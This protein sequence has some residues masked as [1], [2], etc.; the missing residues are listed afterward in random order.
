MDSIFLRLLQYYQNGVYR[1]NIEIDHPPALHT[2]IHEMR[3]PFDSRVPVVVALCLPAVST[4][5]ISLLAAAR[6]VCIFANSS[7]NKVN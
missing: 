7:D 2:H 6:S 5:R 4:C 3:T 1:K